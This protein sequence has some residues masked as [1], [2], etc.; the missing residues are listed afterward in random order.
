[1]GAGADTHAGA[2]GQ[3]IHAGAGVLRGGCDASTA[4]L[5]GVGVG[6]ASTAR[7]RCAGAGDASIAST[8]AGAGVGAGANADAD[9]DADA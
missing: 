1:M 2:P 4:R 8:G 9:A 7:L 5:R 6:D 3:A